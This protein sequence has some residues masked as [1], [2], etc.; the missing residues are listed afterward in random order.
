MGKL[1]QYLELLENFEALVE[2]YK[3]LKSDFEDQKVKADDARK[4]SDDLSEKLEEIKE[5][6][7]NFL[8]GYDELQTENDEFLD[9]N[10]TL[11]D[12][13]ESLEK[14]NLAL[15]DFFGKE[16]LY[17]HLGPEI[18]WRRNLENNKNEKYTIPKSFNEWYVEDFNFDNDFNMCWFKYPNGEDYHGKDK[19]ET[20]KI[21]CSLYT[22]IG[23]KVFKNQVGKTYYNDIGRFNTLNDLKKYVS[24]K[25][26]EFTGKY[27]EKT[28]NFILDHQYT[29][30]TFK[31]FKDECKFNNR[32]SCRQYL[33]KLI[34]LELIQK[35]SKNEYRFV[36]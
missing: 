31:D 21:P 23:G 28:L 9:E 15:K 22:L 25:N 13:I 6:Y 14:T 30:F 36:N 3:K 16:H 7:Y 24:S 19:Y 35:I 2:A 26:E 1:K 34:K 11:K 17:W 29:E 10:K 4:Y 8:T 20:Y 5:E 33:N 12:N 32:E 18:A 27:T